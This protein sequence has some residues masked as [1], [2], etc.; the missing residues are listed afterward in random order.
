MDDL[1]LNHLAVLEAIVAERSISAAARRLHMTPKVVG[2]R[3]ARLREFTGDALL[4][5]HGREM[6]PTP[7]ALQVAGQASAALGRLR[8]ALEAKPASRKAPAR[9]RVRIAMVEYACELLLPRI[10]QLVE[11]RAP[12][13]ELL[14]TGMDSSALD[15][16]IAMS[17]NDLVLARCV[18]VP[19]T[20]R[21][22]ILLR[23]NWKVLMRGDYPAGS[24]LTAEE[25]CRLPHALQIVG[26][27]SMQSMVDREVAK[28]GLKRNIAMVASTSVPAVAA[29]RDFA[30]TVPD[31]IALLRAVPRGLRVADPPMPIP[32]FELMMAWHRKREHD[33]LHSTLRTI[34]EEAIELI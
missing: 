1:D 29:G 19:P 27:T 13:V 2:Q 15:V 21:R 11:E 6:R 33:P 23:E 17:E 12:H 34:V 18:P 20:A 14:V 16:R 24:T 3:L 31:G 8:E 32:P 25:Y 5:R 7:R 4:E 22:S 10:A 28:L 30:V 9:A 26:A